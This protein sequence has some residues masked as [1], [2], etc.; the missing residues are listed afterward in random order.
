MARGALVL[1]D[2]DVEEWIDRLFH[3]FA[4]GLA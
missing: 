1:S 2:V 3:D 4:K